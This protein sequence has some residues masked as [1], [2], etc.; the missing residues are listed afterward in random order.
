[1]NHGIIEQIGT[2]NEI[3]ESPKTPFIF[4]FLAVPTHLIACM[5]MASPPWRQ[6]TRSG[7]WH[8]RWPGRRFR[9]AARYRAV[10]ARRSRANPGRALPGTAIIRLFPREVSGQWSSFF[11]KGD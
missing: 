5:A 11:M 7:S 10:T 1:M 8:S 9:A 2:P 6:G 4:D 3:Y